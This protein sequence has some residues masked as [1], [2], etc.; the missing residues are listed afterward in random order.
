M[1]TMQRDLGEHQNQR[2]TTVNDRADSINNI[3][4]SETQK[5]DCLV[6]GAGFAGCYLLHKLRK[7]GFNAKIV[8]AGT[9][10]GGIWRELPLQSRSNECIANMHAA[11]WNAYVE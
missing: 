8:E 3:Q 2:T 4:P 9:D 1:A 6:I 11:D 7:E 5:I 10:L